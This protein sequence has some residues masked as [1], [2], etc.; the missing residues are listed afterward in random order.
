M[1]K[2]VGK[3]VYAAMLVIC[4][5]TFGYLFG[6]RTANAPQITVI[7]PETSGTMQQVSSEIS[8]SLYPDEEPFLIDINTADE[9]AL[10]LLPGIGPAYAQRIVEYRTQN[11][12]FQTIEDIM[13]VSGIGEKKFEAMKDLITV[14]GNS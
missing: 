8:Q 7:N 11:G 2:T 1:R 6:Q 3:W 10:D 12:P 14:E 5:F 4:A 13:N 9:S